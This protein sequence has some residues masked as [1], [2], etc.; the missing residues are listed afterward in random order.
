LLAKLHFA[1][2]ERNR[3]NLLADGVPQ[4]AIWL[5]GNTVID[6]LL[7]EVAKQEDPSVRQA[8]DSELRQ[9]IGP[10]WQERSLVLITGHRRENFGVGFEA[11]VS[12]IRALVSL[13]PGVLFVYPVHPNPNVFEFVHSSLAQ[14]KNVRLIRPQS[15]RPFVALLAAAT[16][17]LTDSGGVQEEAPSLGKPVLVMR[18]KTERPEGVEAG[19]VRLVGADTRS[20]VK[21]VTTLLTDRQAYSMMAIARNPYGDGHASSRILSAVDSFFSRSSEED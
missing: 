14:Y 9:E 17:V 12:A 16:L 11:I 2:T 8:V 21:G 5:T 18:D 4:E 7:K 6:A 1:P 19:T 13:F 10:D 20:I 3:Q 15:Y